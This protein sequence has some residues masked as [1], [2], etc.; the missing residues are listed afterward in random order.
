M[1]VSVKNR[2]L[3]LNLSR[4]ENSYSRSIVTITEDEL[5]LLI[6]LSMHTLKKTKK[7]GRL[8]VYNLVKESAEYE[9]SS[10]VFTETLNS[11]IENQSLIVNTFRNRKYIS[12]R[13][14][15]FQEN[16]SEKMASYMNF[17]KLKLIFFY[18]LNHLKIIFLILHQKPQE[19]RNI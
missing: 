3:I 15:N 2:I 7:C 18:E 11:L 17:I 6:I 12:L 8:E 14:E 9:I 10:D 16:E 13:N 19:T 4:E 5:T 1:K